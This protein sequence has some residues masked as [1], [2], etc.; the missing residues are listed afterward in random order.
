MTPKTTAQRV[1]EAEAAHR[2]R[3]EKEIRVWVPDAAEA[4][5]KV[6]ELARKLCV[7]MARAKGGKHDV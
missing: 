3:G 1:R 5:E 6:R 4:I 7:K 2:A